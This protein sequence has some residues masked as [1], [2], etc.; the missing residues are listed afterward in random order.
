MNL[1][2]LSSE[3]APYRPS[4]THS[5]LRFILPSLQRFFIARESRLL[6]SGVRPPRL[7]F[8]TFVALPLG[9]PMRFL[10]ARE[11]AIQK[12]PRWLALA[13]L[14]L[15]SNPKLL[16]LGPRNVSP[17]ARSVLARCEAVA[18]IYSSSVSLARWL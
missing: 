11:E 18:G 14:L 3:Q 7:R 15:A 6:P 2:G 10:P 17:F 1:C 13:A 16:S 4:P 12:A 9:L 5:Y 8:F